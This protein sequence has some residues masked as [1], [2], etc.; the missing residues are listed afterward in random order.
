MVKR[1]CKNLQ[2]KIICIINLSILLKTLDYLINNN[3]E[4]ENI[5]VCMCTI[6]KLEN[7][8]IREFIEYYKNYGVDKIFL[9]DN[10]DINSEKFDVKISDY[11][12]SNY[13][14]LFNYRG[15]FRMQNKI[16]LDCYKRNYKKYNWLIFYDIDEFIDLK[17]Y[18]NI[19]DFLNKKK[20]NKCN[21]IYLNWA[22][23]T[24]NNLIYYDIRP[25]KERFTELII[26][27]KYC[28]GKTI[29]RGNIKDI[30]VKSCHLVDKDIKPRCNGF[31]QI[32][33]SL[34]I[35]CHL[36]TYIYYIHHYRFKSTEEYLNKISRGDCLLGN[37]DRIKNSKL[38]KYFIFNKINPSKIN[39]INNSIGL[40]TT[41]L[42]EF[43]KENKMDKRYFN[44]KN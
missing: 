43:L 41:L 3:D 23:H 8:Y 27:K 21:T 14:E 20:F 35:R 5:K 24:D 40:N 18:N 13:V 26:D 10:N 4:K 29:I 15:L 1:N 31:G 2:Y 32:I 34:G 16:N 36:P 17:Y 7:N 42:K 12:K 37:N 11:I 30:N 38:Y 39:Y 22:V 19:K 44:L 28:I 9:Y 33:T 6:G 25:L